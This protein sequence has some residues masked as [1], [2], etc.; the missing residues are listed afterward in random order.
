MTVKNYV[1]WSN[2]RISET[3]NRFG[4]EAAGNNTVKT[5]YDEM[6]AISVA[7]CKRYLKGPWEEITFTDPMPS[8]IELFR[9]NWQRVYDL[10]H[11]EPCNI[12]YLGSDTIMI[13]PTEIFGQYDNY[14]LFNW[15]TPKGNDQFPNYFNADVRYMDHRMSE[16]TWE[17]GN[18]IAKNWNMDIWDQEQIIF[19]KMFWSQN[20][21]WEDAHHP[22][23]NWQMEH[24]PDFLTNTAAEDSY[25][26]CG[27]DQ[28]R[29]IHYHGSR[30]AA[31][32]LELIRR[33]ARHFDIP[34]TAAVID[35]GGFSINLV[36]GSK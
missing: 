36:S 25:N 34:Y 9:Q 5:A 3:T 28:A 26:G 15:T 10:W 20:L 2:C 21:S 6:H 33:M 17:L 23:L 29:I 30:G 32:K 12:I 18:N 7:S 31:R 35:A 27:F 14:R 8:R 19:N 1:V 22:D 13:R 4:I 11:R 24:Y 16:Q